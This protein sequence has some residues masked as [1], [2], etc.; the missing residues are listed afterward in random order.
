MKVHNLK[1]G[2][3]FR[4]ERRNNGK[5]KKEVKLEIDIHTFFENIRTQIRLAQKSIEQ[6][7]MQIAQFVELANMVNTDKITYNLK[8]YFTDDG[9]TYER[10]GIKKIG[11]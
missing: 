3:N 11:F 10:T 2:T 7:E 8:F 4:I 9:M 1:N 6:T 5:E